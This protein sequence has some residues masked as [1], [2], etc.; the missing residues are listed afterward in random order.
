[1]EAGL[2]MSRTRARL[3][4]VGQAGAKGEM[5]A[6]DAGCLSVHVTEDGTSS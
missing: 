1:M 4:L 5:V 2:S 6:A 3:A